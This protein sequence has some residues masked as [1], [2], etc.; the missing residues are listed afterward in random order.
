MRIGH[1]YDIHRLE[2]GRELWL[3]GIRID[4]PRGLLGHSDADCVLHALADA[5]FG[6]LAL[7]DIGEHFPDTDPSWRGARSSTL[8]EAAVA[9]VLG[10]GYRV[11][12]AD[13][14][15]VAEE[16]RLRDYKPLMRKAI[17]EILR[18]PPSAVGIKARTREGLDSVGER[19]AIEVHAVV[20]VGAS[21]GAGPEAARAR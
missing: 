5:L 7:P 16:P 20:L 14:T 8:L 10:L 1:G 18:V 4:W 15:I 21:G 19:R 11:V 12:N 17:A 3:G 6:A 2:A 9:E 13:V